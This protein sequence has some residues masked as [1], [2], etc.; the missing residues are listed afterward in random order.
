MK[1]YSLIEDKNKTGRKLMRAKN[2]WDTSPFRGESIT[3]SFKLYVTGPLPRLCNY[4]RSFRSSYKDDDGWSTTNR[5]TSK[6]EKRMKKKRV[7]EKG[8]EEGRKS[9]NFL[10]FYEPSEFHNLQ[11][12]LVVLCTGKVSLVLP[13]SLCSLQSIPSF[14][15]FSS[16]S[17]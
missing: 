16:Y 13:F 10:T 1:R 17:L 8:E 9:V 4:R 14:S 15:F 7:Q 6:N 11:P 12:V 3:T 5:T 2:T